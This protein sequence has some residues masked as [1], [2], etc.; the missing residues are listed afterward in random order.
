MI[1]VIN[2]G[3]SSIKYK[4]FMKS[5]LKEI[6][7]GIKEEITSHDEAIYYILKKLKSNNIIKSKED[8]DIVG[9]RVVHGGDYFKEA[10]KIDNI[11]MD[12][13]SELSSLAPLHN[14][15]NLSGIKAV[16]E[17]F[18]DDIKQVAVFDTAFHQT[19]PSY[20]SIYPLPY[21]YYE[22]Y[23]VKKYGFHGTSHHY[24]AKQAAKQ[25]GK[26]LEDTNLITM[27][28]GN[29]ASVCAIKNGKSIDTSMGFTPLEGLMMGTRCGNIDS[30]LVVYLEE[31]LNCTNDEMT[32]IL[33]KQSGFKGLCGS[34][35]LREVISLAKKDDKKAKLAIDIFIYRIKEYIGSYLMILEDI[36]AIVFT[37]GIGENSSLVRDEIC[38][39]TDKFNLKHFVIHTDEELAIAELSK[40]FI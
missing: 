25:L 21:E 40:E 20:A 10:V 4:L 16:Y 19:I 37:G 35:D 18:G 24:V 38:N 29:G 26:K 9:H 7:S 11:V 22:K 17:V 32:T 13:I 5:N 1:L 8:I 12:K 28:L 15:A 14:P 2:S 31:K 3:S 23:G 33:N 34:S 30:S 39:T 36:D 6:Y 27:H